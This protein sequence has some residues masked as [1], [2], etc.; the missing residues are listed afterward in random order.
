MRRLDEILKGLGANA[1]SQGDTDI[2][3]VTEA[4]ERVEE[5]VCP[6]CRGAGFVRKDVPLDDTDFGRAFPCRCVLEEKEEERL[7]RLQ[8]YSNLG[9]LV[10]LT[11]ANLMSRG[12]STDPGNQE[13]FARAVAAAQQF[14][15]E[16]SGWLVLGGPSGCGKTHLAAAIGNASIEQG[17]PAFFVVVP[18]LLDH[19]RA[20]YKPGSEV[21]Y[22]ELFE[23]VR[24]APLVILDD[25]GGHSA[26]AWAQEKLFQLLNH[27]YNHRLPTVF[28]TGVPLEEMDE[29]LR[30]RL[31]DASLAQVFVLEDGLGGG[32]AAFGGLA[33]PVI[34]EMTFESFY[35]GGIGISSEA[36]Q[37]LRNAFRAAKNYAESPEGWLVL[38]GRTGCGKTHLAAAIGHHLESKGI[39]VEFCVVPDLLELLRSSFREEAAGGQFDQIFEAAR[40]TPCLILDDL[41]VHSATPWAQE[42]LFQILNY[43]YNAKLP[44]VITVGCALDDLPDSWVSRMYDTKVSMIFEI[45]APDYRGRPRKQAPPPQPARRGGRKRAA[46]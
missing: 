22:D 14:A 46:R 40:T 5:G 37:S 38:L 16:P 42:K 41:G 20:A 10:R 7:A 9:P 35:L 34:R 12:R 2:S 39:T 18:D 36:S 25:L 1:P 26:T 31:S 19:L 17:R 27:R 15:E 24:N 33:L 11:F 3:S 21:S 23:Q 32:T 29:R 44:T 28:T 4:A 6:L 30:T 8:R 45:E 13:R 43:R